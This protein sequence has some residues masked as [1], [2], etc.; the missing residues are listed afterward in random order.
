MNHNFCAS[1]SSF[2]FAPMQGHHSP[3]VPGSRIKKGSKPKAKWCFAIQNN[4]LYRVIQIDFLPPT[5]RTK[6]DKKMQFSVFGGILD[7]PVSYKKHSEQ[8]RKVGSN[9]G[10]APGES[11]HWAFLTGSK[12]RG[13]LLSKYWRHTI[14]KQGWYGGFKRPGCGYARQ[15]VSFYSLPRKSQLET[16]HLE[17]LEV[18]D[19]LSHISDS[20]LFW[21][22]SYDVPWD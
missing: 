22:R 20:N 19:Y 3:P 17:F 14:P 6:N 4:T 21:A 5:G 18:I 16:A 9:P 13:R 11:S 10:T 12:Q 8:F 15:S 1:L 2:Q 7:K